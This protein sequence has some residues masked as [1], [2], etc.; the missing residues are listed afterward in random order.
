MKS[1]THHQLKR[2]RP[3]EEDVM[4]VESQH[5]SQLVKENEDLKKKVASLKEKLAAKKKIIGLKEENKRLL[6]ELTEVKCKHANLEGKL[7]IIL[8]K[9]A[10]T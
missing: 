2:R 1:P 9:Q 3:A 4:I 8:E 7:A 5:S 6:D 10:S